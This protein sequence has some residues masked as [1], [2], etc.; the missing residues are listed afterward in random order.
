[1][2]KR[3]RTEAVAHRTVRTRLTA[4]LLATAALLLSGCEKKADKPPSPA[5]QQAVDIPSIAE[6]DGRYAL[7]VDGAPYLI[8]GA[9]MNNWSN[10]PS[11]LPKVWPVVDKLGANTLM[12]PVA[13]EQIESREGQFDY[14]Y[15]DTLIAQARQHHVRLVL[16]WFG[17]WKNTSPSYAPAWVKLN[18][19]RFPRMIDAKG[20]KSYALSPLYQS[21]LDADRK[22]FVSLMTYLK[23]ADPER[24]VIMMQVENEPGAYRSV[25]DYSP[26]AQKLFDGPV[27]DKLLAGLH[28]K[29]GTW[30]QVFGKNADEYFHAWY[31]A[32]FIEQIAAA[33]HAVYRLP[34]FTN[35]ALRDPLQYQDPATYASGG[36]TWNVID[37][38]KIAA[39]TLSLEAPDVYARDYPTF[40][41][42][43]RGYHRPDNP[44]FLSEIGNDA[45]YAR[46]F[47]AVLGNQGIAFTPFGMDFTGFGN[48]PLGAKSVDDEEIAP[49]ADNFRLV[50]PMAREWA[51]LSFE[52]KVWGTS[53]PEDHKAQTIDLGAWSAKI[54]YRQALFWFTR[55]VSLIKSDSPFAKLPPRGGVLI[56]Q[57]GPGEFLLTGAYVRVEFGM[58]DPKSKLHVQYDRVEEG[59]YENG[60]WVFERV[61]NGDQTDWGLN[62]T[63]KPRV[64]RVKLAIF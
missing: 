45:V 31:V 36:P 15:V 44:L 40:M 17:T 41:A 16:L 34:M 58:A 10:Y 2:P 53:E 11:V 7:M 56:A 23:A 52:S 24:T 14:S 62:F 47:F 13:W 29:P 60:K 4:L 35:A 18:N 51:K 55:D 57:L 20:N 61:L 63:S 3:L 21:T 43:I 59:R 46:Y 22:A 30:K 42:H 9:Q 48:Y 38:Y 39:P 54:S 50:A 6:K 8:L 26:M 25:R 28:K 32:S 19:D 12:A 64:L 27:P 37:I 1:M 49:F 5:A 33:G